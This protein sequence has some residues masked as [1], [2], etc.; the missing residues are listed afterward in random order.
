[1]TISLVTPLVAVIIG[2][3]ALGEKLLPQTFLGGVLI[4]ASI[5][6]IILRSRT[7]KKAPEGIHKTAET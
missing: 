6:I 7:G 1:M 2:A 4:L 3:A 5:G